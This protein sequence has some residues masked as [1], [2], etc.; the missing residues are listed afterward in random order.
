MC[1]ILVKVHSSS[2][3]PRRPTRREAA[4]VLKLHMIKDPAPSTYRKPQSKSQTRL[5]TTVLWAT[6]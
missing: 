1:S 5:C 4:E 6:Q 2:S 3:E